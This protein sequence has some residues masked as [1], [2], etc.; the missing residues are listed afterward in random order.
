[1]GRKALGLY[2]WWV[3]RFA[4]GECWRFDLMED[5]VRFGGFCHFFVRVGFFR[6]EVCVVRGF[7]FCRNSEY[8]FL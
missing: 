3:G 2:W 7:C 6:V 8:E 1:M 4:G 5:F